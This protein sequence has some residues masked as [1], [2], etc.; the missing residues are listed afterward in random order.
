MQRYFVKANQI[1]NNLITIIDKDAHHIK[2]V[3]RFKNGDLVII[4]TEAGYLYQAK[5]IKFTKKE[6]ILEI[7]SK[8]DNDYKPLNLDLGMSLIKKDNFE[9][10]LQKT[11]ELGIRKII[12]LKT[13]RSIIKIDDFDK[14]KIRYQTI[15][16]EA[17]EQSERTILPIIADETEIANIDLSKYDYKFIC[18]AREDSNLINDELKSYQPNKK[19]LVLIGPEGGFSTSEITKYLKLGFTTVSLGKTILR[20]ETAAIYVTSLFRYLE[21]A[22]K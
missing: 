17:S 20:A 22:N 14:K 2:D 4:N 15:V 7:T 11:T 19:A 12:P 5:I 16:K 8:M 21:E 13:E 18:F 1:N 10:V 9:L 6:V 3:M